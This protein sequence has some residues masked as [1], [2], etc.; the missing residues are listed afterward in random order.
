MLDGS[1]GHFYTSLHPCY[2]IPSR[3]SFGVSDR[4]ICRTINKIA[5]QRDNLYELIIAHVMLCAYNI[6]KNSMH[7]PEDEQ[8]FVCDQWSLHS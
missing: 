4:N 3:P 1:Q 6:D 5:I 2:V 7:V 8:K